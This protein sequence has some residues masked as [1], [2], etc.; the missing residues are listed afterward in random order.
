MKR[1]I[2]LLAAFVLALGC[3]AAA[4]AEEKTIAGQYYAYSFYADGYGDYTFYFHFYEEDPVL[5]SVFFAGLSNNRMNFAGLYTVE[6][7][8]FEYACFPTREAAAAE[9]KVYT[10]GTAPYTIHFL[11]WNGEEFDACGWDGE[12][13]YN[14]CKVITG[15]GSGDMFYHLDAEHK[16]Q[17][18]YDGETGVDYLKFVAVDDPTCTVS[19][20]HNKTY[21]DMMVYFI[22]GNWTIE[23]DAEGNATYTLK[24]FDETEDTVSLTVAADQKTAVYTDAA[25]ET[26]EL[27]N[28]VKEGPKQLYGGEATFNVAAYNTDAVVALAM[29]ED[30]TCT[31][32]ASLFGN[33]A[34]IDQGTYVM[35]ADHSVTFTLENAGEV[36][37]PLDMSVMGVVLHYVNGETPVG[38]IDVNLPIGRVGE[39]SAS[40]AAPQIILSFTGG[41]TTFDVYDDGTYEFGFAQYGLKEHGTWKFENYQFSFTQGNGN[42]VTASLD[43]N[44]TMSFEYVAEA[45]EQ[46]KDTFTAERGVWGAALVK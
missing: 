16:Y 25:G 9:E 10:T 4:T 21:T 5:G 15:A 32:S 8:P 41:Y 35:N 44:Y 38:A 3:C 30:D 28:A 1:I 17:E 20:C 40:E 22:D 39:E 18:T 6:E 13:L 27:V 2:A 23:K 19:L 14:N 24:P 42:T 43:E 37:A 12:I 36:T 34:V 7:K 29:F 45:N 26:T 31:I 11:N 33:S 46:L